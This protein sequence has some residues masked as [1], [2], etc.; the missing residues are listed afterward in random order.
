MFI[1]EELYVPIPKE[2]IIKKVAT[3][4]NAF[5]LLSA[6]LSK[7]AYARVSS[8]KYLSLY[9]HKRRYFTNENIQYGGQSLLTDDTE[10]KAFS[11][12]RAIIVLFVCQRG[13]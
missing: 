3:V 7:V 1:I 4:T 10:V 6:M 5:L 9:N 13:K 11:S 8:S 12:N 2:I